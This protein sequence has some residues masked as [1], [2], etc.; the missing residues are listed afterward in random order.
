MSWGEAKWIVNQIPIVPGAIVPGDDNLTT[1]LSGTFTQTNNSS[2]VIGNFTIPAG[3]N[4][5]VRFK[6]TLKTSSASAA[7]FAITDTTST[8][9][10]GN[11]DTV[12][13]MRGYVT[14]TSTTGETVHLDLAVTAGETLYV[15]I[16]GMSTN[17]S[18]LTNVTMGYDTTMVVS[19]KLQVPVSIQEGFLSPSSPNGGQDNS[20]WNVYYSKITLASM[21][22]DSNLVIFNPL[23]SDSGFNNFGFGRVVNGMELRL[24]QP[25]SSNSSFGGYWRVIDFG[26]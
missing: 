26:G 5:N 19:A 10:S 9:Y 2:K 3:V 6:A 21:V 1:V 22:S 20:V 7:V 17:T 11:I 13:N 24:Y 23:V 12:T 4:G 15:Q 25:G 16:C 8:F 18:T 14:T